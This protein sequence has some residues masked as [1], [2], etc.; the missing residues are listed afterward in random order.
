MPQDGIHTF[1]QG[2]WHY[3]GRCERKA[4]LDGEL[5]WQN[6]ILLCNDCYDSYPVFIGSI[7]QQQAVVLESIVQNPDLRPNEKLVNPVIDIID[8]EILL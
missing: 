5:Q 8:S 2:S 7:E 1:N 3:C 6:A 4:K